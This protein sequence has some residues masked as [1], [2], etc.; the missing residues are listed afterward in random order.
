MARQ[1]ESVES[2]CASAITLTMPTMA[3]SL[4]V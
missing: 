4:P 1:A 3:R 2:G